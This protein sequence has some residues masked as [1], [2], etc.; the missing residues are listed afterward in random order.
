MMSATMAAHSGL[1]RTS[2]EHRS[3]IAAT[4]AMPM[5]I[6]PA[7]SVSTP[8]PGA[9]MWRP[10]AP[11]AAARRQEEPDVGPELDRDEVVRAGLVDDPVE[12]D[13][14]HDSAETRHQHVHADRQRGGPLGRAEEH[15][16]QGQQDQQQQEQVRVAEDLPGRES[17]ALDAGYLDAE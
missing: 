5:T 15:H 12:H 3:M 17:R 4:T 13:Q 7:H 16:P 2:R 1:P 9:R 10:N 8:P 11:P 6:G 14:G